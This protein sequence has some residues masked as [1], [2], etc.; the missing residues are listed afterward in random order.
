MAADTVGLIDALGMQSVH[1]VGASMG[2]MIAQTVAIE[3]PEHVRSLTSI[4][5]T[6]GNPE[7]GQPTQEALGVLLATPPTSR[8]EAIERAVTVFRVIGSPG[9]EFDESGVSE[10]AALSYDR[11]DDPDGVARQ[12]LAIVASPDRTEAL[13]SLSVPTVVIHGADDALVGVSGGR[14]TAAAIPDAELVVID[15][16]GHDVPQAL[17]PELTERIAGRRAARRIAGQPVAGASRSGPR[18]QLATAA[19]PASLPR[20]PSTASA[21]SGRAYRNPCP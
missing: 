7:V 5:S 8:E 4:M 15:G 2:G 17:W 6:T 9:F 3:H 1:L 12:M 11:A 18:G 10:R 19:W 14:A 16:M 21:S 20:K 13:G